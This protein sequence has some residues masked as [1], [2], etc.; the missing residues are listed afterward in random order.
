MTLSQCTHVIENV[1]AVQPSVNMIVRNDIFRLN[2]YPDARYGVFAWLQGRHS[3]D[4]EGDLVRYRY[5]FFYADR[6]TA[7]HGN[8]LEVQSVGVETL[9]NIVRR[10]A[11][12]GVPAVGEMDFTAFNQRFVDECAGV[13]STLTFE[14]PTGF[15][16]GEVFGDFSDDF[17]DDFLI[18]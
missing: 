13:Y 8:E 5:T 6:L 3:F 16:C 12:L 4:V 14:V 7:D 9:S 10:L 18:L 2:S 1:A 17:S 15:V 11:E